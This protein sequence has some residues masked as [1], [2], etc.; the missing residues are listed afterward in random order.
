MEDEREIETR[1]ERWERS[2]VPLV[3]VAGA[4]L[5]AYAW[6]ILDPRLDHD[7]QTVLSLVTWTAWIAFAIDLGIRLWLAEERLAY[8]RRHWYDV[9]LVALPVLRP[10]RL[11]RLLALARVLDRTARS[12]SSRALTYIGGVAVMGICLGSLAVLQAERGAPGATITSFGDAL[13]WAMETVT[14]VGYGDM[15]PVTTTGRV[16]AVAL[17]LVGIAVIG[18]ITASI[19]AWLMEGVRPHGDE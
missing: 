5:V 15:Y 13:W 3:L 7:V 17:M 14:T 4:F 19:A 8:A 11:L 1:I 2:E 9:A 18:V 12:R 6:P 10:L 16:I